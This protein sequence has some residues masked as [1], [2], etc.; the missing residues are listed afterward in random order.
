MLTDTDSSSQLQQFPI[1]FNN[2]YCNDS[3]GKTKQVLQIPF[4][5]TFE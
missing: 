5:T 4:I 3:E 1:I 2:I